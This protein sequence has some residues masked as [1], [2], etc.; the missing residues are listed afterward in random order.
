MF[1]Y[2]V[3]ITI[4]LL[5]SNGYG[6]SI[7]AAVKEPERC[8]WIKQ[9]NA[10]VLTHIYI[11]S[12]DGNVEETI[13]S[14]TLSYDADRGLMGIKGE[15]RTVSSG[16][17]YPMW[18]IQSFNDNQTYTIDEASKS[19]S[20]IPFSEQPMRCIPS[21]ASYVNESTTELNGKKIVSDTWLIEKDG[22]SAYTTVSRDGQ[23]IPLKAQLRVP[24]VRMISIQELTRFEPK[25]KDPSIMDI[26]I[27]CLV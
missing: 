1:H 7:R 25:I 3:Y 16:A 2:V 9:Y 11:R 24:A 23:C 14:N 18:S 17:S 10:D 12:T 26:P 20:A 21:W 22:V 27:Q 8:C 15:M 19:C 6:R 4:S 13:G 5:V